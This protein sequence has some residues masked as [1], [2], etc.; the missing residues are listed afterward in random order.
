[1]DTKYLKEMIQSLIEDDI[2]LASQNLHE[3]LNNSMFNIIEGKDDSDK[4]EEDSDKDD[5]ED[6]CKCPDKD[7]DDKDEDEDEDDKDEE[8][9][10]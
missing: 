2:E 8:D 9:K 5:S 1:M 4:K 6:D 10:D 7:E 3:H